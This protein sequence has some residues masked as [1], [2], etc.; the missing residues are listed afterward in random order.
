MKNITLEILPLKFSIVRLS[1]NDQPPS[2]VF[3]SK[4][5]Y[6]MSRTKDELSIV[7]ESNCVPHKHNFKIEP[8]WSCLKVAGVLDFSLTGI[9]SSIAKP[10][11]DNKISI[12]AISTFDTDYILVREHQLDS[13]IQ[14]LLKSG[15][16][17]E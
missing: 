1:T 15:F 2:W 10:L 6:S 7:V 8:G 9:L 17:I 3:D 14:S 16:L 5:F 4:I 13:A 11:A 12:F